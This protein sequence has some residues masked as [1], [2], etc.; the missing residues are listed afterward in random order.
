MLIARLRTRSAPRSTTCVASSGGCLSAAGYR[1]GGAPAE[2]AQRRVGA[3]GMG[4]T[5]ALSTG[6]AGRRELVD[7]LRL[8]AGGETAARRAAVGQPARCSDRVGPGVDTGPGQ[9]LGVVAG[10]EPGPGQLL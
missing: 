5:L 10:E 9:R 7:V 4:Q 6:R 8:H 1:A 2:G 3:T